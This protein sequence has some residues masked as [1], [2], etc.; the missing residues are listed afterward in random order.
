MATAEEMQAFYTAVYASKDTPR[1]IELL[2]EWAAPRVRQADGTYSVGTLTSVEVQS[3]L[4]YLNWVKE[5]HDEA[6]KRVAE[7]PP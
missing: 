2:L 1:N 3:A 5:Q 4:R 6:E 7:T